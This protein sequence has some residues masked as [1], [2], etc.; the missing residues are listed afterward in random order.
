M[1]T[2]NIDTIN[3]NFYNS[4]LRLVKSD[5]VCKKSGWAHAASH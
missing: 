1:I 4:H 5:F 3:W 2:E